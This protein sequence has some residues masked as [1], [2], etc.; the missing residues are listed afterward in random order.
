MENVPRYLQTLFWAL[1]L[2]LLFPFPTL[3]NRLAVKGSSA[4]LKY[5]VYN[6]IAFSQLGSWCRCGDDNAQVAAQHTD[7][8]QSLSVVNRGG[9]SKLIRILKK[10]SIR[11]HKTPGW[12]TQRSLTDWD[13]VETSRQVSFWPLVEH[14]HFNIFS[15]SLLPSHIRLAVLSDTRFD[16]SNFSEYLIFR[17][18]NLASSLLLS[19]LPS[20]KRDAWTLPGRTLVIEKL[21]FCCT[22]FS[23]SLFFWQFSILSR[24]VVS[25]W[26]RCCVVMFFVATLRT[27][28]FQVSE[29]RPKANS[30]KPALLEE[31]PT[32]ATN[33]SDTAHSGITKKHNI[34]NQVIVII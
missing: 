2:R 18:K 11:D 27:G 5:T 3:L 17:N 19:L 20:D 24:M 4:Q 8:F 22:K 13:T 34:L 32:P 14:R 9:G 7:R 12:R 31:S 29:A 10:E 1:N 33:H 25:T 6:F 28:T 15:S 30:I 21:S 16:G 23:L 26:N